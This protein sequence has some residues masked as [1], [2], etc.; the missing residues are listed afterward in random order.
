[1]YTIKQAAARSGVNRDVGEVGV[2][3]E[4]LA[5]V[6]VREVHFDERDL[7]CEQGIAQRDA[8]VREARGVEDD[9]G[10]VARGRLM[11]ARDQLGFRVALESG[12]PM[13][14]LGRK[15]CHALVDL[16][17]ADVTVEAWLTHTEQIQI[18]TVQQR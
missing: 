1:M 16:L 5:R 2:L 14:G 17:E 15:L 10:P 3:P 13:T 18:R 12:E 6:H 7:Y 9:E 4:T 8:R 11:Y